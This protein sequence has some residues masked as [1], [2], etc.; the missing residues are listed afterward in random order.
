[1]S[2]YHVSE[3]PKGQ[4]GEASKIFEEVA[5]F[6]DALAQG[7]PVLALVELSDLLGA[8]EGYAI[9]KY[10]IRLDDLIKLMECTK[11]SFISGE[12]K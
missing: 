1:M 4:Y 11:R 7:S 12:R 3:I 8:I 5:E 9:A 10:N 2:A 6:K